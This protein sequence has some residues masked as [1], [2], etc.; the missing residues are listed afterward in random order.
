[1]LGTVYG[2]TP[3]RAA[4]MGSGALWF[5]LVA[6]LTG[7]A[8]TGTD[9]T[10]DDHG[11]LAAALA[12]NLGA[13]GGA[14]LGAQV[15]PSIARVRFVDLGAIAGGLTLGGLYW[16]AAGKQADERSVMTS[17]ALGVAAGVASAWYLTRDMTPDHP[18][19]REAAQSLVPMLVPLIGGGM[20]GM[21]GAF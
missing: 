19:S 9:D 18:R 10:R 15:S 3:G 12:L 2:S 8:L 14:Y 20:V 21:A 4:L 16:A 13:A 1:V 11:W 6:G 17:V 7:A 5:G